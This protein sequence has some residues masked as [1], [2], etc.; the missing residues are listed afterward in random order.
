MGKK[1]SESEEQQTVVR[2][3]AFERLGQLSLVAG[4]VDAVV[5]SRFVVTT[6]ADIWLHRRAA[7][8]SEG[9]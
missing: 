3:E 2:Y 8:P 7:L 5:L 4:N 1:H 9:R 6:H